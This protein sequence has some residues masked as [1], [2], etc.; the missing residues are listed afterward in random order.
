MSLLPP[1]V[2]P[3][4]A[5]LAAHLHKG[6][7][8]FVFIEPAV[9]PLRHV[10]WFLPEGCSGLSYQGCRVSLPRSGSTHLRHTHTALLI[11][12]GWLS[13]AISRRLGHSTI[14]VTM[15]RLRASPA[16]SGG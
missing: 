4:L 10:G 9:S 16:Q 14:T 15:D 7:D 3:L 5:L 6:L 1:H 11:A 2:P 8:A 13:L 12:V